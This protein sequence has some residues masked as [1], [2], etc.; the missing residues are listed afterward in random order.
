M[1]D[2]FVLD[3]KFE[4]HPLEQAIKSLRKAHL[5]DPKTP[6]ELS[7]LSS[8]IYN[9]KA[10]IHFWNAAIDVAEFYRQRAESEKR[11]IMAWAP[12]F[13]KLAA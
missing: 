8:A 7:D 1:D 10:L 2:S 13:K 6:E 4:Q 11:P 5:F 3:D 12:P 9:D